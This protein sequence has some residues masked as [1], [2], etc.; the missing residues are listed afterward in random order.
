MKYL[1]YNP[2]S[3]ITARALAS[4]LGLRYHKNSERVADL[5]GYPVIRYGNSMGTF[6]RD[7]DLNAPNVIKMCSDSLKFCRWAKDNDVFT[8]FYEKIFSQTLPEFPFLL[9]KRWHRAG[10]DI[11]IIHNEL[12]MKHAWSKFGQQ[13]ILTRYSV[14]LYRTTYELRVHVVLDNIPR[15]FVKQ[16][17]ADVAD[18]DIIRTSPRGWH[19]SIRESLGYKYEKAQALALNIAKKIGLKFGGIDMAW[20]PDYKQYIIWEINTAPGLSLNSLA[21]YADALRPYV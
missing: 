19:Y 5:G 16:R 12:D 2:K 8:P 15:I 3:Y 18:G 6:R 1:L 10:R 17:T 7:T 4:Q 13:E 20:C 21:I 14:P 11:I 9:R